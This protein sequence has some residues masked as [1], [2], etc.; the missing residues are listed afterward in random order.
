MTSTTA[1]SPEQ[2]RSPVGTLTVIPW[3]SEPTPEDPGT[4]M[5]M[6]YSLGDGPEGPEAAVASLR[7]TLEQLGL[8]AGERLT[9][10]GK[11]SR[12]PVTL[13]VE[14]QQAVLTLPFMKVQCPVPPEWQA[15]AHTK[16]QVY[17]IFALRP[18]PEAVPGQEVPAERLRAFVSDEGLL[19]G[20]AHCLAPVMRVRT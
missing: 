12:I 4:P 5:L 16:E 6:V 8:S 7:A 18:W 19:E 9:D 2:R 3:V 15:A 14:A 1:V 17:L 11:D 10:L 20:A 13:L